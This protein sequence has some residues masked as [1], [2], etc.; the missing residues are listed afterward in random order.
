MHEEY[1]DCSIKKYLERIGF[2]GEALPDL[3]TLN[4]VQELHVMAVPYENLEIM[5]RKP[6]TLDIPSLYEKIVTR[7]RGGY[8]GGPCGHTA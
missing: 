8:C 4:R 7:G 3:E 5:A 1:N 6:L 2:T